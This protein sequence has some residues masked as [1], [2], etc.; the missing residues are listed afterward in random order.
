MPASSR[1]PSPEGVRELVPLT[2]L[3]A[4]QA[5]RVGEVLGKEDVVHRL[6]EMGLHTGAEIQMIRPGSPCIIRLE[7]RKLGFRTGEFARVFVRLETAAG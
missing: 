4:G 5:G 3:R 7:G 6:R 2:I 1:V